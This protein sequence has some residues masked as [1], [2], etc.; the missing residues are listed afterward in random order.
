MLSPES[1]FKR[2]VHKTCMLSLEAKGTGRMLVPKVFI[3][4]DAETC[5][6]PD[7]QEHPSYTSAM[8]FAERATFESKVFNR[9]GGYEKCETAVSYGNFATA[10]NPPD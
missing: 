6:Y 3:K 2:L 5:I 7:L 1:L 4:V 10:V 9:E 8:L